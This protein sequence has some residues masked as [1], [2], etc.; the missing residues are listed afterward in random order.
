M[1]GELAAKTGVTAPTPETKAETVE[2]EGVKAPTTPT[3]ISASKITYD[4]NNNVADFI[5]NVHV[6]D[7]DLE[8]NADKLRVFRNAEGAM[9]KIIAIGEANKVIC[10]SPEGE[11]VGTL[12][13]YDVVKG[14]LIFTG[15]PILKFKD[16]SL[17]VDAEK[18]IYDREKKTFT[19]EGGKPRIITKREGTN[20]REQFVP[21]TSDEKKSDENANDA[22]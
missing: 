16:G 7:A 12:A 22:K 8:L 10:K 21:S 5:G 6:M 9:T 1:A 18:V 4:F 19:T 14:I 17:L 11:A 13:T 15:K 2:S 3:E 20:L